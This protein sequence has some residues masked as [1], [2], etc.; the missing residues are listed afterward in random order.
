[1]WLI[2]FY[3]SPPRLLTLLLYVF[4]HFEL[5]FIHNQKL[6][7]RIVHLRDRGNNIKLRKYVLLVSMFGYIKYFFLTHNYKTPYKLYVFVFFLSI[8]LGNGYYRKL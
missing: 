2:S 1:M 3:L 7:T 8:G 4:D 6:V 5:R